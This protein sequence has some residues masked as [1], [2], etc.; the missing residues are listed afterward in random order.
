[1][2][3]KI[4]KDFDLQT[5]HLIPE[6]RQ[7]IPLIIKKKGTWNAVPLH[8]KVKIKESDQIDVDLDVARKLIKT[9]DGDYLWLVRLQQSSSSW[10]K[11]WSNEKS[12]EESRQSP[13][14]LL[15]SIKILIKVL[16][17]PVKDH[18][19]TVC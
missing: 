17:T 8:E 18:H 12:E 7:D 10:K 3:D 4:L 14:A 13:K 2:R 16:Q 6:R 19:L 9:G 5:D 11:A 1:M 15:R